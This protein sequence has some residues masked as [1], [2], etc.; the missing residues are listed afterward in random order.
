MLAGVKIILERMKTHPE[1][2]TYRP[3][4]GMNKWNAL[5]DK[6]IGEEILTQEEIDALNDGLKS[7]RREM[8]NQKVMQ[9]MAEI[10]RAHV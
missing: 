3:L 1:D 4:T 10:G 7:C 9:V 6:A 2:F 8:F 5:I